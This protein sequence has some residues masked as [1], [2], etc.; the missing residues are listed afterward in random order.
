VDNPAR[1]VGESTR[2]NYLVGASGFSNPTAYPR[3]K[4]L[5]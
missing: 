5:V 2:D 3:N 1:G 4:F